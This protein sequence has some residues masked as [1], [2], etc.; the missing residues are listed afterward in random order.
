MVCTS[1]Y[2]NLT[3]AYFSYFGTVL[4]C[5]GSMGWLSHAQYSI[6]L[7]PNWKQHCVYH[8]QETLC[9]D[10]YILVHTSTYSVILRFT[11]ANTLHSS[12]TKQYILVCT[13][14]YHHN[15]NTQLFVPACPYR[16]YQDCGK[17][18]VFVVILSMSEYVPV[19]T[20]MY[21]YVHILADSCLNMV[22]T[23]LF[24]VWAW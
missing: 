10:M 6:S 7:C 14:T 24:S 15:L 4:W 22:C 5:L 21:M 2:C 19:C 9:S 18:S 1:T 23:V 8:V 20:T 12:S 11:T 17:W 3:S 13:C 16:E